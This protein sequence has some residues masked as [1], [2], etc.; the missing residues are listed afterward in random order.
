[1]IQVGKY[2]ARA[3]GEV[4][5]GEAQSENRTPY[6]EC[7]FRVVDGPEAGVEVRWTG[8]LSMKAG[9]SGK[10]PAERVFESLKHCGWQSD[11]G[12]VSV[13]ADGALHGINAN[14]VE[15][16]VEHEEYQRKDGTP[17]VKAQVRWVNRLGGGGVNVQNRMSKDKADAVAEK[18]RGLALKVLTKG[19]DFAF[20]ENAK[21]KQAAGGRKF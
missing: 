16:V 7:M 6:I 21:P 14:E 12:D 11:D 20:G 1:M 18:M 8:W 13:F 10:T 5:L 9:P 2:K 3:T 17:G 19:D 4:V 15:I